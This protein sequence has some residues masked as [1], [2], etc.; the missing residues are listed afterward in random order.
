M[1]I[2][3]FVILSK[4]ERLLIRCIKLAPL[5]V[6]NLNLGIVPFKIE[7]YRFVLEGVLIVCK[8]YQSIFGIMPI[9][10]QSYIER[11]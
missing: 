4:N 5:E 2:N 8:Y 11:I 7:I 3:A 9:M 10:E 6:G 1:H